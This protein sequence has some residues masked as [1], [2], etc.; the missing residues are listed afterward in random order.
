MIKRSVNLLTGIL[1]VLTGLIIT[2]LPIPLGL[3]LVVLGLSVLVTVLPSLRFS[4]TRLRCRYPAISLK[5]R[6]LSPKLPG[7]ARRLLDHTDP[8][9]DPDHKDNHPPG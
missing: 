9:P 1:L 2:P 3:I 8:D 5:L 6:R 4:L 7:F